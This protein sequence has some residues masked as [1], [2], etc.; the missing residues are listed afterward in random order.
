M[1][2]PRA[3]RASLIASLFLF[4]VFLITCR[5][6]NMSSP[7]SP[8]SATVTG[9]VVSGDE[10]AGT[11]GSGGGLAGVTV[12]VART[13]QSTQTDGSGNFTI[14]GV[15]AG[16][17]ELQFS[18]GNVNGRATISMAGGSTL[19]ITA[20]LSRRSGVVVRPRGNQN[21]HDPTTTQ[22]VTETPGPGTPTPGTPTPRSNTVE[23]IEGIVTGNSGG[24]LTIFDQRL[25]TVV[26]NITGS[27]IIRKGQMPVSLTDV[28]I[29][30]R[31]HVM[32]LMDGT[33][34]FTALQVIVQDQNT[35]T[36]TPLTATQTPTMTTTPTQTPG[37]PPPPTF[38]P[39]PTNTPTPGP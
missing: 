35:K 15:P 38:T 37:T 17:Q 31:V 34:A 10:T 23:Q 32:A 11:I 29:G 9:T 6:S 25:G 27:T 5:E 28:L 2:I 14:A 7:T 4:A 33:G 20:V 18:R 30:M 26:V 3:L 36:V 39:T 8:R 24:T 12:R 13:G 16:D 1:S 22:T 21:P 19:S